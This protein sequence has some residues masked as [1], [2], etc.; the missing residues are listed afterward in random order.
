MIFQKRFFKPSS[1]GLPSNTYFPSMVVFVAG[2]VDITESPKNDP[3]LYLDVSIW[4]TFLPLKRAIPLTIEHLDSTQIGWV[5]GLFFTETGL[6]CVSVINS[7]GFLNL[8][9]TLY[10]KSDV[11][12]QPPDSLPP[13]PKLEILHSWL[14]GLS[15]SS[16]HPNYLSPTDIEHEPF[17]HVSICALGKRRGSVAVYGETL[18][19]V[20]SKFKSLTSKDIDYITTQTQ[21]ISYEPITEFQIN[22]ESLL[23][24]LIDASFISNRLKLLQMDKWAA[25]IDPSTYLKASTRPGVVLESDLGNGELKTENKT[26]ILRDNR[27]TLQPNGDD[28]IHVPKSTFL[29]M[30]ESTLSKTSSP[31]PKQYDYPQN[32]GGSWPPFHPMTTVPHH[33]I[34]QQYSVPQMIPQYCTDAQGV[35]MFYVPVNAAAGNLQSVYEPYPKSVPKTTKRKRESVDEDAI[36]P[37]EESMLIKK[38]LLSL[39]KSLSEIQSELRQLRQSQHVQDP[40]PYYSRWPY[41]YNYP[42]VAM[43]PQVGSPPESSKD[44]NPVVVKQE[45]AHVTT[46]SEVKLQEH[47]PK[48]IN[49]SLKPQPNPSNTLQKLFCDEL[50]NKQ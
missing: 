49:A 30:L 43:Q 5:L 7:E 47:T 16:I 24:K 38:D 27:M 8:L 22:I 39:T 15:L 17:Q 29:S 33:P 42:Q 10:D 44:P 32:Y 19:W 34:M 13:N 18:S 36:F 4:K 9:S 31:Q 12:R 3:S 20:L 45:E 21:S 35:P 25:N 23:G 11:A 41:Y 46:E 14:P 28:L 40:V 2:F 1:I 37:G 6:F 26:Q 50:L 48:T